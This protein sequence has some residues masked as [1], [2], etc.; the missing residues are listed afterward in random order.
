MANKRHR[1]NE[2]D[3]LAAINLRNNPNPKTANQPSMKVHHN[4]ICLVAEDS[5]IP[6]CLCPGGT[7]QEDASFCETNESLP[8]SQKL[9]SLIGKET[10]GAVIFSDS[11]KSKC[12]AIFFPENI[13]SLALMIGET[14]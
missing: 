13:V 3:V 4:G 6:T 12:F 14:S 10:G 11:P 8:E 7:M 1:L 9:H 2:A 5:T